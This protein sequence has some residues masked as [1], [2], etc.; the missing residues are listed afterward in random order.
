MP[1]ECRRTTGRARRSAAAA[2]PAARRTAAAAV[3]ADGG[4]AHVDPQERAVCG[5]HAALGGCP[6]TRAAAAHTTSCT[7][8]RPAARSARWWWRRAQC[9]SGVARHSRQL[10]ARGAPGSFLTCRMRIACSV[11]TCPPSV[12]V[13][14][15]ASPPASPFLSA[16][17]QPTLGRPL[18][19][20][21]FPRH[22]TLTPLPLLFNASDEP[23]DHCPP[24]YSATLALPAP[25]C[26]G[27]VCLPPP[28]PSP[29]RWCPVPHP[30]RHPRTPPRWL[31]RRPAPPCRRGK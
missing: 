16:L 9:R 4:A 11:G 28:P 19:R 20:Y 12:V 18:D 29:P 25:L 21:P 23:L 6:T 3:A 5:T 26:A 30:S 17:H 31:L 7:A 22:P 2:R 14:A 13:R 15:R 27:S 1:H 8:A 10:Q 24:I